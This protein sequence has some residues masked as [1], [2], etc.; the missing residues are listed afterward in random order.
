MAEKKSV[1]CIDCS[2]RNHKRDV[3]KPSE[4]KKKIKYFSIDL[5]DDIRQEKIQ[6]KRTLLD[7]T[8]K[9]ILIESF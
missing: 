4:Q 9:I 8:S 7:A 6:E 3:E 5:N 1:S 2:Y